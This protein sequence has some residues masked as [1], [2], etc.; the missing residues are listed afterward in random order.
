M[1]E[2]RF[3]PLFTRYMGG[4]EFS[5]LLVGTP[6]TSTDQYFRKCVVE[7]IV[8]HKD[9]LAEFFHGSFD[10]TEII[11]RSFASSG[12][13]TVFFKRFLAVLGKPDGRK[14]PVKRVVKRI[15][16]VKPPV[17]NELLSLRTTVG[18]NS[19]GEGAEVIDP[20]FIARR[21]LSLL[22]SK[23]PSSSPESLYFSFLDSLTEGDK[24]AITYYR[25]LLV[26]GTMGVL[27]KDL[28]FCP[29]ISSV[30]DTI[31]RRIRYA[32]FEGIEKIKR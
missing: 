16:T 32:L 13:A 7:F 12:G 2:I 4:G 5:G 11:T 22:E 31:R 8:R 1:L 15:F 3:R 26:V 9:E 10:F 14:D 21:A 18:G 29:G 30:G 28:Q 25:W 20:Y 17:N 6:D 24:D 19:S 27:R 23:I